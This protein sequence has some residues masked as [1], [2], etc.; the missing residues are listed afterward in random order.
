M[1][2]QLFHTLNSPTFWKRPRQRVKRAPH[3]LGGG[4]GNLSQDTGGREAGHSLKSKYK[5]NF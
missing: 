2:S 1:R 4:G 3:L 5:N